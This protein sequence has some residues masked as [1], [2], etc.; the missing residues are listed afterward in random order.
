MS[1]LEGIRVVELGVWVAG[2]SAAGVMADWGADVIKVEPPAGD[3]MR[4][5]FAST[6][7]SADIPNAP[8][9]VDNRGKRSVVLDLTRLEPRAA[10]D[11][12]LDT[13]DV[14]VTNLRLDPLARLGLLPDDV[15]ASRERLVYAL[16]TGYGSDGPDKD[17]AGYDIGAFGARSG[18]LHQ[19]VPAGQPPA[20]IPRGLGDHATGLATLAGVLGALLDRGRTGQGQLVETSLLRTGIYTLGWDIAIQLTLGKVAGTVPRTEAPTPTSNSYRCGDGKWVWLLGVEADRHFP[21]LCKA[22]E[23]TDLLDDE[24]FASARSRRHNRHE[25]IG[26]LDAE[27]ATKPYAEWLERF[28]AEDVWFAPV[29]TPGD[30]VADPQARASGAFVQVGEDDGFE[31]VASPVAFSAHPVDRLPEPP[32]LG[33]NTHEVLHELGYSEDD[34]AT[35]TG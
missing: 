25:L 32:E 28:D 15:R 5:M 10:L 19:M 34:I 1:V 7:Y 23:R 26:I 14:F 18:V 29:Q 22:L 27:F 3:P 30:V 24:R 21:R 4:A 11:R 17:R 35:V 6:G 33:G 8:F 20:P 2:P 13:A 16:L 9:A 12:L 31:S